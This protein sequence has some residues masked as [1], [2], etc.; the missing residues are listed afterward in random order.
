[1]RP[2]VFIEV[3]KDDISKI[4][5]SDTAALK[6]FLSGKIN[7]RSGDQSKNTDYLLAVGKFLKKCL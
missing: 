6:V 7:I 3:Y 2:D 4:I 1:M 5:S